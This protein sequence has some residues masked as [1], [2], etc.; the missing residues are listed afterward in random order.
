[1]Q[2]KRRDSIP[3][4]TIFFSVGVSAMAGYETINLGK[5]LL[6]D[7]AVNFEIETY[8]S[9]RFVLLV[10]AREQILLG[11]DINKFHIQVGRRN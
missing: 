1:M 11:S 2:F 4:K 5:E 3:S 7:G 10:N 9:N 8:L 6:F